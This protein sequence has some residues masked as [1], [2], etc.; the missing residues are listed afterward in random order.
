MNYDVIITK[1]RYPQD[2]FLSKRLRHKNNT[3]AIT[4][5]FRFLLD[6]NVPLEKSGLMR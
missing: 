3:P 4:H 2:T 6:K 1:Q 5:L